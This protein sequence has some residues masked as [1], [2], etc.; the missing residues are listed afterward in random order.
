[1]DKTM[2]I[3]ID[4]DIARASAVYEQL[5][6]TPPGT[7]GDLRNYVRVFGGV[8]VPDVALCE[9]H[10]TP[11]DYLWHCWSV[12]L[13][14]GA[15]RANGDCVVWA[16]RTGGKTLI[17]AVATLLDCIF[18]ADCHVRI[19][20]G[21]LQQSS[22][23]YEYLAQFANEGF[24]EFLAGEVRK[25]KCEFVNGSSAEILTQSQKS[26]RGRHVQKLR[27]DEVEE[28]DEAN[29]A[30][31]KFITHTKDGHFAA[32][33]MISTMHHPYGLMQKV[34]A[35]AEKINTPVFK[36]CMW[37]VVEKCVGRNCSR[38]PLWSDC[39]GKAKG[40]GGYLKI[41]DC[42]TQ[43]KRSSR[44]GFESEMLCMRPSTENIVFADFD[45][46]THVGSI[47]YDANLPLYRA[48]DFG[49][50]N[51][52]VCLWIQVDGDGTVRIIDE[53]V[54]ARATIQ[55]HAE[56]IKRR[57]PCAEQQV[58]ATFCDPAGAG[59]NDVTGTSAVR[60]LRSLGIRTRYRKSGILE[61]IERIRHL[62]RTGDGQSR[63]IIGPGCP[64]LIE[65]M[66]CYHYPD[67]RSN[68]T[69]SELPAK[70]CIYD[71]P[72]DALRYFMAGHSTHKSILRRY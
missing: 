51:P 23:M 60:E 41:D 54:R 65:A 14:S 50:V 6:R 64:R 71:H 18:K 16:N 28:F 40:A 52:F 8:D 38:C 2:Q 39:G 58:T 26:I 33:E 56:E 21:S 12:D 31:A 19:L 13:G 17:A 69:N 45:V 20:G 15:D 70:D 62:I 57:T 9:G 37:E 36:W 29:F 42:I 48:M 43:M 59:R 66:Q 4:R 53:Y 72:I 55:T 10:A 47:D 44:A 25:Q 1:M 61:G 5:K 24:R 22:R 63:L 34:I 35:D 32:M 3:N 7:R 46:D 49:F 30:A 11:M 68:G 27:C 67:A